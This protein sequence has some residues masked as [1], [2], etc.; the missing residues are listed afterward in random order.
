MPRTWG[1][2]AT[3]SGTITIFLRDVLDD[4][5]GANWDPLACVGGDYNRFA[6]FESGKLVVNVPAG[7]NWGKTGIMSKKPLFTVD[8]TMDARPMKIV[9]DFVPSR[10]TGY[11]NALAPVQHVDVWVTQNSGDRS[12]PKEDKDMSEQAPARVTLAVKAG[13]VT[14]ELSDKSF[15][16]YP[17]WLKSGTPVYLHIFSHPEGAGGPASFALDAVTVGR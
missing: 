4:G 16:P 8:N 14:A 10:T 2:L 5:L 13:A 17:S 7:N 15:T 12:D 3:L 1:T 9:L 6:A 11:V